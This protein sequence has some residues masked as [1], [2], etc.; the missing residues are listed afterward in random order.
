MHLKDVILLSELFPAGDMYPFRL[1]VF[2]RTKQLAFHPH[3]TFFIGENGSGKSTLLRAIAIKCGIHLWNGPERSSAVRNPHETELH[4][5]L[6]VRWNDGAVPGAY[7][8]SETFNGYARIVDEWAREDPGVLEYYGGKNLVTQSH[9]QSTMAYF[10][11]RF[12]KRGL[13]LL[14]EP[15]TALSPRRQI[16]LLKSLKEFRAR[17]ETQFIIATHSPILLASP[18]CVIYSFDR[19][20][21]QEVLYEQTDYYRVYRDFMNDRQKYL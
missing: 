6:G 10:T 17:G 20:P 3:L 8:D 13:Y 16:E 9:G 4:R 12:A 21:I 18:D 19:A 5:F 2:R 7:F 11:S 1:E 14:D 15:E